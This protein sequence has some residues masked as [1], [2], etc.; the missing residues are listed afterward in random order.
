MTTF[1][2][3][4]DVPEAVTPLGFMEVAALIESD[5]EFMLPWR[6]SGDLWLKVSIIDATMTHGRWDVVVAP[7]NNS[8]SVN[9]SCGG[10]ARVY[11]TSLRACEDDDDMPWE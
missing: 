5:Q 7:A 11:L 3:K 8:N 6:G 2:T 9:P 4:N 10:L 1:I